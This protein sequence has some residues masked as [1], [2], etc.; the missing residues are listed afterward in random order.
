MTNL[1]DAHFFFGMIPNRGQVPMVT[2]SVEKFLMIPSM[3]LLLLLTELLRHVRRM[4]AASSIPIVAWAHDN[5]AISSLER[6]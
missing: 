6:P 4:T 2:R 1:P 5:S 3:W